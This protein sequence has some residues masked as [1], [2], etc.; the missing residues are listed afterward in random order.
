MKTVIVNAG[1]TQRQLRVGEL[2]RHALADLLA[3]GAVT[4]PDLD[5]AIVTVPEVRMSPDLK[6]ATCF[7]VPLGNRDPQVIVKAM[8]RN[9][10]YL[11]G[12]IARRVSLKFA[13]DLRFRA[14][15]RFDTDSEIDALLKSP[16]VRRDLDAGDDRD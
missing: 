15:T 10:R 12:Q 7:V 13:P 4:D 16:A 9:A 8:A 5:G 3:R 2:V 11:R 14:D 1:P 6:I